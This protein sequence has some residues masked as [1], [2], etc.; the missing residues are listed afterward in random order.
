MSAERE[1][2]ATVE[3]VGELWRPLTSDEQARAEELLPLISDALRQAAYNVGKDLDAIIAEQPTMESVAKIVTVDVTARVLR[4]NTEGEAM[5]QESQG[6][7]G[8]QWSGTYA[9]PGGGI[10]NAIMYN[11]LKRLGLL[12]QTAGVIEL[13]QGFTGPQ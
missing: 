10:A 13:W 1:P 12:R 2:F 9:V 3:D 11:D 8:Y 5:S 4:Q 7:L 6:A